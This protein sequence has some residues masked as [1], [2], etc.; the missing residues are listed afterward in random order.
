MV[1]AGTSSGARTKEVPALH[2][3]A[4]E[5][6]QEFVFQVILRHTKVGDCG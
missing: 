4:P 6:C 3:G 2:V 1:S 5:Q